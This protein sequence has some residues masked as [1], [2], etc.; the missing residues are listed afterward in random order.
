LRRAHIAEFKPCLSARFIFAQAFTLQLI[1]LEFK[2]RLDLLSKI[3][4]APCAFEHDYA[5]S[6]LDPIRVA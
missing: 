5:S 6:P 3:I 2:M 4:S 1:C